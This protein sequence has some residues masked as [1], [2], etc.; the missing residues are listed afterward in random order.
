MLLSSNI[1]NDNLCLNYI[2]NFKI[3]DFYENQ[4]NLRKKIL[5]FLKNENFIIYENNKLILTSTNDSKSNSTIKTIGGMSKGNSTIN[6]TNNIV[7]NE[8]IYIGND[9]DDSEEEIIQ[10]EITQ[11]ELDDH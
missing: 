10:E 4:I 2:H 8:Q 1:C 3:I 5:F 6:N 9:S 11:E 7:E